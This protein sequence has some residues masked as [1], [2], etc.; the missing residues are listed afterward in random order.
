MKTTRLAALLAA[1][2]TLAG[3]TASAQSVVPTPGYGA[4]PPATYAPPPVAVRH[5]RLYRLLEVVTEPS[6]LIRPSPYPGYAPSQHPLIDAAPNVANLIFL[7]LVGIDSTPLA[8][9]S[10]LVPTALRAIRV[11]AYGVPFPMTRRETVLWILLPELVHLN[12]TYQ[13]TGFYLERPL[14]TRF[15]LGRPLFPRLHGM[16]R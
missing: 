11:A 9:A 1:L 4:A 13:A 10:F 12:R 14:Y 5:P 15:G 16:R 7:G 6:L 2:L 8:V 3:G